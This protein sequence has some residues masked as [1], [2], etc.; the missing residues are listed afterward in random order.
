VHLDAP[1]LFA[2]L[3]HH[4]VYQLGC[5]VHVGEGLLDAAEESLNLGSL[6][7]DVVEQ[8]GV[9]RLRRLQLGV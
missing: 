6:P 3:L 1:G 5:A 7:A 4:L 9:V 8:L 2:Q